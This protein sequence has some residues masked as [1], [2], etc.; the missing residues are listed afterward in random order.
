MV[1]KSGPYYSSS[2]RIGL[3]R[4]PVPVKVVPILKK[5][6]PILF[7]VVSVLVYGF[8]GPWVQPVPGDNG[9]TMY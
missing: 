7:G 9:T 8:R 2:G 3:K 5:L 4:V 6:V 1:S